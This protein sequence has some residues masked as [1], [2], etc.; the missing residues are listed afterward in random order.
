MSVAASEVVLGPHDYLT[1]EEVHSRLPQGAPEFLCPN[2]GCRLHHEASRG[3]PVESSTE[4]TDI[5][6][7]P[8]GCGLYEHARQA[9]RMRHLE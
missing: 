4:L 7:C 5:Y 6:T 1:T 2:C 8:A 3:I 9:H